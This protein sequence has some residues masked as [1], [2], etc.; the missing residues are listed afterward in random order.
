[1]DNRPLLSRMEI[2]PVPGTDDNKVT[3]TTQSG[4]HSVAGYLINELVIHP[5]GGVF[6]R[7]TLRPSASR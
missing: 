1:M 6:L 3:V 7:L 5:D 4:V 2:E